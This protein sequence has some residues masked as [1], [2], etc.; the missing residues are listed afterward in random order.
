[1]LTILG[2]VVV[3]GPAE[4]PVEQDHDVLFDVDV[5]CSSSN[6][7]VNMSVDSNEWT[8]IDLHYICKDIHGNTVS[9]LYGL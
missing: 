7:T 9:F 8:I 4:G 2:W 5:Q 1:M 3:G 6:L